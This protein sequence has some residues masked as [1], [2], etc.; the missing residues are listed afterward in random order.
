VFFPT[1]VTELF[2]WMSYTGGPSPEALLHQI[3][4]RDF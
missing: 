4:R 3:A 1:P 2:G